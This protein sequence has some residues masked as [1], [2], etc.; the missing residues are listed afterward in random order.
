[1]K[2]IIFVLLI[3]LVTSCST[4]D[5]KRIDYL[6]SRTHYLEQRQKHDETVIEQN[7]EFIL[8]LRQLYI[9]MNGEVEALQDH[10]TLRET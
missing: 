8:M 4:Q 7:Q 6:E 10:P 1:M 5:T 3:A 2:A 9:L